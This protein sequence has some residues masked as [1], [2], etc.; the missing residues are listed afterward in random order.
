MKRNLSVLIVSIFLC[1]LS[2][3]IF[4][5]VRYTITDLGTLGGDISKA[6]GINDL[7]QVVGTSYLST[8]EQRAFRWDP[9]ETDGTTGTMVDLGTLP[10]NTTSGASGINN[11]GHT[12]GDASNGVKTTGFIHDGNEMVALSPPPGIDPNDAKS[13]LPNA[14]NESGKITGNFTWSN[15]ARRFFQWDPSVPN[16]TN[17]IMSNLGTAF[18]MGWGRGYGINDNGQ[19]CGKGAVIGGANGFLIRLDGTFIRFLP[20]SSNSEGNAVNNKPH[21]A[22]NSGD[23]GV[24]TACIW[25]LESGQDQGPSLYIGRLPGGNISVAYAINESDEVVGYSESSLGDRAF[26]WSGSDGMID[27]NDYIHPDSG[28]ELRYAYGINE[29]GQIIGWGINP[30]GDIRGFLLT[31][32]CHYV[33]VGDMDNNCR[34]DIADLAILFRNWLIDCS[35]E[36]LNPACVLD[37]H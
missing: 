3:S 9:N 21:V 28:W 7:G 37:V 13:I 12:T 30:D 32:E 23:G 17:G 25:Y 15:D 1:V 26:Y 16:D 6:Y 24:Y 35:D 34:F 4:A 5:E 2:T 20:K 14:I 27:L 22:G 19:F 11:S 10:D 18:G 33:L 29:I 36:P 8:G 31:P